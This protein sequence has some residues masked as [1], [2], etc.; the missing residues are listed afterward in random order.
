MNPPTSARSTARTS[1]SSAGRPARSGNPIAAPGGPPA[2]RLPVAHPGSHVTFKKLMVAVMLLAAVGTLAGGT[3]ATFSAQAGNASTLTTG[4]LVLLDEVNASTAT[5]CYSTGAGTT[6]DTNANPSCTSNNFTPTSLKPGDAPVTMKVMVKNAGSLAAGTL[7]LYTAACTPGDNP[8]VAFH[9]AGD[10]CTQVQL[11]VQ[12]WTSGS[13]ATPLSCAY[14]TSAGAACDF[15]ATSPTLST[16]TGAHGS[17]G[18]ALVLAGGLGGGSARYFTVALQL[19]QTA[20]NVVQG[21]QATFDLT[22]YLGQ[23]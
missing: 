15:Q 12:E 8:S 18:S 3:L 11:Y 20:T 21:R 1:E 4:S 23:I 10:P 19:P 6:T 16:F 17:A 13:Y 9:A 14:G 22:W 7:G 5:D 2:R